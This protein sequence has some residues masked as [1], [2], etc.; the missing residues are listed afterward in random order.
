[1]HSVFTFGA[2]AVSSHPQSPRADQESSSDILPPEKI[3]VEDFDFL[4][5]LR[6]NKWLLFLGLLMGL[7]VATVFCSQ[8][9]NGD[10]SQAA[11]TNPS[12]EVKQR[13]EQ[14]D[15][16]TSPKIEWLK[17]KRAKLLTE[18]EAVVEQ[19][20]MAR[21][22]VESLPLNGASEIFQQI[23]ARLAKKIGSQRSQLATLES[24]LTQHEAVLNKGRDAC[25][26]HIWLL[27]SGGPLLRSVKKDNTEQISQLIEVIEKL[28]LEKEAVNSKRV[29][30]LCRTPNQS[31]D[32]AIDAQ[33]ARIAELNS[34][35]EKV[36]GL[37]PEEI[38]RRL[39]L[40]FKQ[41]ITELAA[42]MSSDL[43]I[44]DAYETTLK[45]KA[46]YEELKNQKESLVRKLE[47]LDQ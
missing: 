8:L 37:V 1:M 20:E 41:Q 43:A 36:E 23:N 22:Q 10:G 5:L 44:L 26:E 13:H 28:K 38:M 11:K 12:E 9:Q 40:D 2:L 32:L 29:E 27:E 45:A 17:E 18:V 33:K 30:L 46:E 47:Y 4:S 21:D 34:Q 16:N 19:L 7:A 42:E 6:R 14:K 3:E 35:Q 15:Q 24:Q 25:V 31:I 39:I